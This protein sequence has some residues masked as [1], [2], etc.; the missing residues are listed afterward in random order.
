M[1][2]CEYE[3]A[4]I[5]TQETLRKLLLEMKTTVEAISK[6]TLEMMVGS[7]MHPSQ[8]SAMTGMLTKVQHAFS[9]QHKL[10]FQISE[11]IFQQFGT[12]SEST[13]IALIASV[14]H[15][16]F[17]KAGRLADLSEFLMEFLK[18]AS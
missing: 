10:N 5:N 7:K 16:P 11:V 18:S 4:W 2:L 13:K 12:L 17:I 15:E 3:A 6:L 9:E 1:L 8:K 14:I